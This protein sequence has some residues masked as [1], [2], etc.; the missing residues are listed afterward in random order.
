[1]S[2]IE[3]KTFQ[4]HFTGK[5]KYTYLLLGS[6]IVDDVEELADLLWGL[7]LD[8]VGNSLA[9]NITTSWRISTELPRR[10]RRNLQE[11]L[12]IEVVGSKDN[13]EEHLLVDSDELL[14]PLADVGCPLAGLILALLGVC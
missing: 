7:T 4:R 12:D 5:K 11:R 2:L 6:E 10:W 9:S 14:V 13:L 1:M 3:R 8:H